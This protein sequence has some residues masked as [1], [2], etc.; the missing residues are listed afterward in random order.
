MS[1]TDLL[2]RAAE[3]LADRRARLT[4]T[5]RRL[6]QVLEAAPGPRTVPEL[7]ID[8][9]DIPV[10][11]LYRALTSLEEAQ[12]VIRL[13][14]SAGTGRYELAEWITGHHHHVTCTV[15]GRTED[16]AVGDGLETAIGRLLS[17]VAAEHR[18]RISGHRIEIEG[19]CSACQRH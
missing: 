2:D 17:D 1:Q 14:D 15:C 10:S 12:V 19:V 9:A 16:V 7:Q 4:P 18:Y 11:S 8:L 13:R 5:R 3:R 6:L